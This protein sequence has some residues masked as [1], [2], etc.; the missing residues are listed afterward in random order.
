M[1]QPK[2]STN[3]EDTVERKQ[4]K[5]AWKGTNA[6]FLQ[7]NLCK[8]SGD[9]THFDAVIDL[10]SFNPLDECGRGDDAAAVYRDGRERAVAMRFHAARTPLLTPLL[11]LRLL[12]LPIP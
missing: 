4:R 10:G 12:S 1:P 8:L 11:A 7:A 6:Q 3:F 5:A 2:R 9:E